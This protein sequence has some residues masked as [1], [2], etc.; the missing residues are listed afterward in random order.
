MGKGRL[1]GGKQKGRLMRRAKRKQKK[2]KGK[3]RKKRLLNKFDS[4]TSMNKKTILILTYT[5]WMKICS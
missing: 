3:E 1:G 4:K 5:K 2:R